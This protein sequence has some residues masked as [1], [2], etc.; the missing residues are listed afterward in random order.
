MARHNVRA[1]LIVYARL[2]D[3][4][5]RRGSLVKTKTGFR[6]NAMLLNGVIYPVESPTFQ[7]RRYEGSKAVYTSVGTD[8][9]AAQAQL[10]EYQN[11][12]QIEVSRAALGYTVEKAEK[13]KTLAEQLSEYLQ[14][15]KSPSL[16]LSDTAIRH[17]EDTLPAFVRMAGTRNNED[18]LGLSLGRELAA[19]DACRIAHNGPL[20]AIRIVNRK[21]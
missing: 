8:L 17:Y 5:W 21:L 12:R 19:N 3:L 11:V 2:G 18:L 16:K 13:T 7:I 10:R 1:S 15:K 4:G 6:N 14:K 20:V 9:Q